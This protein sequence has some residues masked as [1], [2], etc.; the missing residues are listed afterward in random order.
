MMERAAKRAATLEAKRK[1]AEELKEEGDE[2]YKAQRHGKA[3]K[4]YKEAILTYGPRLVYVN[5]LAAAYLKLKRY[6]DAALCAEDVLERDP[7]QLKARFRRAM[8]RKGQGD[9]DGAIAD[10]VVLLRHD[11]ACTEAKQELDVLRDTSDDEDDDDLDE[12]YASLRH[13][14]APLPDDAPPD[15]AYDTPWLSESS[16]FEHRGNGTPC[17]YYNH[18]GCTNGSACPYKHAPDSRSVRDTSGRN[19]CLAHLL[20]LCTRDRCHY[21]HDGARLPRGPWDAPGWRTRWRDALPRA[22]A[23]P[24]AR[25]LAQFAPMIKATVPTARAE[26]L[27]AGRYRRLERVGAAWAAAAQEQEQGAGDDGAEGEGAEQGGGAAENAGRG[28]SDEGSADGTE[29][30]DAAEGDRH[31]DLASQLPPSEHR[32]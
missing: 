14:A 12:T 2:H 16:D 6:R 13:L 19:V 26:L 31:V 27:P 8:A 25:A 22:G 7:K 5:H 29:E 28:D 30:E 18:G 4:S 23:H 11:P 24:D 21:A 3:A 10:L 20:G 15:G 1:R 9:R 32:A 17:R